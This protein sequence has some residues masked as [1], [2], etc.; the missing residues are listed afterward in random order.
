MKERIKKLR[1]ALDLTQH[2]FATRIGS[3]QNVVANYEIGRRNP[4]RSV[5]NNICKTFHVSEEWLKT[6]A[7]EMFVD[8]P[9]A[10]YV[11]DFAYDILMDR[12]K[13]FQARFLVMLSKLDESD[14]E[15][16]ERMAYAIIR[17]RDS[18]APAPAEPEEPAAVE[19]GS[20]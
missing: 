13:S 6:G 3:T 16:L 9:S 10:V 7:G 19:D 1:K 4:S 11:S 15:V 14:W 20:P 18:A 2:E 5:I 8:I 12:P 17:E